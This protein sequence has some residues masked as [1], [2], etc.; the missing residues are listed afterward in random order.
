M[1]NKS[2]VFMN[3]HQFTLVFAKILSWSDISQCSVK[4]EMNKLC[5]PEKKRK[6][7]LIK[8]IENARK[9]EAN[10]ITLNN[11]D[12]SVLINHHR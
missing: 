7:K 6:M 11:H 9:S 1:Q 4:C 12:V 5:L 3:N 8:K 10:D 2:S